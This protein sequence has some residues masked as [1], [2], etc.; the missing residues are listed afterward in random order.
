MNIEPMKS[1]WLNLDFSILNKLWINDFLNRE[2][3]LHSEKKIDIN[4][5][6]WLILWK[7]SY[8]WAF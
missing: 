5:G 8:I 6:D 7:V 3:L 4:F 1:H 2:S